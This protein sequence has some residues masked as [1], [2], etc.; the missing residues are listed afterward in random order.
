MENS[1]RK[2]TSAS[3]LAA[4]CRSE[5]S[6]SDD[7]SGRSLSGRSTCTPHP[8]CVDNKTLYN[9]YVGIHADKYNI[10]GG[11]IHRCTDA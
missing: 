1:R 4:G 10:R 8:V 6:R 3:P 5:T 11:T 7:D 9:A 2:W